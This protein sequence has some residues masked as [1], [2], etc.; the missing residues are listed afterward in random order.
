MNNFNSVFAITQGL[1]RPGVVRQQ[2]AWE[3]VPIKTLDV[4]R[5]LDA[6][7]DPT[8]R[9][10]NYWNEFKS[11]DLPAVPFLGRDFDQY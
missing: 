11:K 2:T 9:F 7:T 6:L 10:A 5:Q 3:A 1:K 8:N 4:F